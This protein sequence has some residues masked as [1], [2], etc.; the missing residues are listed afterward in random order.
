MMD[1]FVMVVI[2][3]CITGSWLAGFATAVRS[4]ERKHH[5]PERID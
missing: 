5:V 2:L 3:I 4:F 1:L